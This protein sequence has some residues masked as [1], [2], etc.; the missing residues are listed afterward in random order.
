SQLCR[1]D[2][3]AI[4]LCVHEPAR[5]SLTVGLFLQEERESWVLPEGWQPSACAAIGDTLW[6]GGDF[7]LAHAANGGFERRSHP[8]LEEVTCLA[9]GPHGELWIGTSEALLCLETGTQAPRLLHA[10]GPVTAVTAGTRGAALAA[11]GE[12]VVKI[13]A[14]DVQPLGCLPARA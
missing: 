12:T 5:Q 10:G 6:I 14:G 11:F 2:T 8:D 1:S 9:P 7:G 13:V 4:Q 3:T